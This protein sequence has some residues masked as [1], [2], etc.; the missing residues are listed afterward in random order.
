V[1]EGILFWSS[2]EEV[3]GKTQFTVVIRVEDR[4]GNVIEKTF[5]INRGRTDLSELE[6]FNTFT[7]NG[8]GTNDTWG[9]PDLRYYLGARVQVFDRSGERLFYTEDADI[10]WDGVYQGKEMPT[11][12]Y[13][14][15]IE[16][17]ETGEVRR[18][19]LNLLRK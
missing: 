15:I 14:W 12:S 5:T 1:K 16:V 10:R 11:G 19:I 13:Y 7:P 8:D 4:D 18:G 17:R 6:V 9:V 2:A 3:A